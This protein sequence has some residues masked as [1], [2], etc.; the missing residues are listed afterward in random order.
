MS[1]DRLLERLDRPKRTGP[2]A[3]LCRCPAHEDRSPSLSVREAE[4]GRVLIHCFA[5]CSPESILA[6]VGLG[7]DDL[8][9]ERPIERARPMR[10]PFN[11][12]DVLAALESQTLLVC[13][14]A[15]NIRKGIA[16]TEADHE[17]LFRAYERI[18]EARRLASG[19]RA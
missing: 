15:T 13:T 6:A 17:A 11:A 2:G 5:G 14:A 3:Y 10:R 12:H 4:D 16:L 19:E 7:F 9:P 8:F 1:V 18:C